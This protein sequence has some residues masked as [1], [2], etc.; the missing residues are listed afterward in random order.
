MGKNKWDSCHWKLING[1]L[2]LENMKNE[3]GIESAKNRWYSHME[4][5]PVKY[6]QKHWLLSHI[7]DDP[8]FNLSQVI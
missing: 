8:F 4:K 3:S 5:K 1:T 2:L 7:Q 6:D